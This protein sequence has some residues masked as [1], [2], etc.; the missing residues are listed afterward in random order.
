MH[1]KYM[2][3]FFSKI[4]ETD[5]KL[6]NRRTSMNVYDTA[7]KL[8]QEIKQSEE[9]INYKK[10]KE[11]VDSNAELKNKIDEFEKVRYETQ[12]IALQQG[13]D[14]EAKMRHL[15]ELYG[16]LIQNEE[17]SKYFDAEMKF[18]ILI[19]DVNKIIG[20]VVQDLMK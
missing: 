2:G 18:N 5:L 12:L 7:N 13:T 19:A 6:T 4:E 15:Q 1:K 16:K 20:Q 14:D 10:I 17:A 3:R 9:Y 8:A 11:L